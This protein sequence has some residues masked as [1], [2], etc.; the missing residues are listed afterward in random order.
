ME[1]ERLTIFIDSFD[2][3]SDLWN[4]YFKIFNH[5]WSDCKYREVLVTNNLIPNYKN[6]DIINIGN[7]TNWIDR[8]LKALEKI[9]TKYVLFSLEDYFLGKKVINKDID[10][11]LDFMDNEKIN[12]YKLYPWPSTSHKFKKNSSYLGG[13]TKNDAYAINGALGIFRTEYLIELIKNCEG[14]KS[15]FDF[16]YY[17]VNNENNVND[18]I[19]FSKICY[20]KR[21]LLGYHNGVIRGKWLRKTIKFYKKE[22]IDIDFSHREVMSLSQTLWYEI[23]SKNPKIIRKILRKIFKKSSLGLR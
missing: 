1:K 10:N 15:S 21:D 23:R 20:D 8:T 14:A 18:A 3:Y 9:D 16:E 12:I 22:G 11:I 19:D 2:G 5:Y 7:E 17:Y 4:I 6:V 13:Y